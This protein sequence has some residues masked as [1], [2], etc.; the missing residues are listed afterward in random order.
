M[1]AALAQAYTSLNTYFS[2]PKEVMPLARDAAQRALDLEPALASAHVTLGDVRLLYDWDWAAAEK[3]YRHALDINPNLPDA[4]LGYA[5]YL[6][7]LGRFDEAIARVQQAYLF[8]PLAIDARNNALWIYYFSGRI[9]E[10]VQ[11]CQRAIEIAP[12]AGLPRAILALAYAHLGQ[13]PQALHAADDAVRLSK[14][15]TVMITAASALAR[16]GEPTGAR[17]LLDNALNLA[18]ELYVC[19]FLVAAT[20]V[21]LGEPEQA[22]SSLEQAFLQRST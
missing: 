18:K 6:A 12:A 20:Y 10:T 7:T 17:Q 15:P 11:H 3:E 8:N 16:V 5:T 19:R 4:Q 14:S 21:D 13:R 22:F 1:Y 9:S 2:S